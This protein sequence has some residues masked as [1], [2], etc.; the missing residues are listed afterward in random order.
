ME[1]KPALIQ[2]IEIILGKPLTQV[3]KR[4]QTPD[5]P[6]GALKVTKHKEARYGWEAGN[7]KAL[8]LADLGLTD[9]KWNA[10]LALFDPSE[11]EVLNLSNNK[12]KEFRLTPKMQQL[13]WLNL[14]GNRLIFPPEEIWKE[15]GDA[16]L[17]YL[18]ELEVQGV[19]NVYEV[20]LLIVGEGETGKTTLWK[21][22][23][24]PAYP[25]PSKEPSTIGIEIEEGWPFPHPI[26]KGETFLVNLW[27]FGGQDIQYMTHQFFLTQRSFYILCAD[28]RRQVANFSY[29]L[30]I[31]NL[32]GVTPDQEEPLPVLVVLNKKGSPNPQLPYD[33]GEIAKAYPQLEVQK[34]EVDFAK[35]MWT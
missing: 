31:I 3:A 28:G 7:I 22:L 34:Y 13:S 24:D 11:L 1:N 21:L 26:E 30:K 18:R 20:K 6:W 4:T 19:K 35:K 16:I 32:L 25:V 27:D 15:G 2:Q 5:N 17:R 8:N 10:I 23:Q 33:P 9:E 12:V 14:E 29:W